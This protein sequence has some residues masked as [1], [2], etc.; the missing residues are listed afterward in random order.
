MAATTAERRSRSTGFVTTALASLV[1]A[2][3][4]TV[5]LVGV[6]VLA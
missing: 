4:A 5:S 6:H 3:I 1:L 2:V